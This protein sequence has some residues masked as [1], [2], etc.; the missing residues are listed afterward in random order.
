M[1]PL[2]ALWWRFKITHRLLRYTRV[3]TIYYCLTFQHF[4]FGL[5][6]CPCITLICNSLRHSQIQIQSSCVTPTIKLFRII[7]TPLTSSSFFF[8]SASSQLEIDSEYKEQSILDWRALYAIQI[9]KKWD[10]Q[11]YFSLETNTKSKSRARPQ[12][13]YDENNNTHQNAMSLKLRRIDSEIS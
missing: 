3:H 12:I 9:T 2:C 11:Y 7:I 13:A 4:I 8:L 10:T 1:L 5:F 6:S